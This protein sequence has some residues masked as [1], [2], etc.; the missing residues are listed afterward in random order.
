MSKHALHV[1]QSVHMALSY[2]VINTSRETLHAAE[3]TKKTSPFI[4]KGSEMRT[5]TLRFEVAGGRRPADEVHL[6]WN[7]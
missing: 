7:N 3:K 4:W 1:S 5:P 6:I 2:G